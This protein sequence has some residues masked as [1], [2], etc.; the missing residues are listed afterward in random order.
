MLCWRIACQQTST[1]KSLSLK[2]VPSPSLKT[3]EL[4]H[5]L[6]ILRSSGQNAVNAS[7]PY[8]WR[9]LSSSQFD[10]NFTSTPQKALDGR[11]IGYSAGHVLGGSSFIS[12]IRSLPDVWIY[13]NS[14]D[15]M[16]YTRGSSDDYDR[17]ARV[18]GDSG[19]SWNELLPY[20]KKARLRYTKQIQWSTDM[21]PVEW[22]FC[23]S[24]FTR[25][26]WKGPVQSI[27][28][29]LRGKDLRQSVRSFSINWLTSDCGG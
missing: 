3:R 11:T 9:T 22:T 23:S 26:Q 13:I 6:S 18:T 2:L 16:D 14:L 21:R 27:R 4:S 19:W 1:S 28:P 8:L 29:R 20:F 10:W 17:W 5:L 15:A 7:C 12:K 24:G 25:T